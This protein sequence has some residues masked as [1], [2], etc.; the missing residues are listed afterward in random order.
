MGFCVGQ[1]GLLGWKRILGLPLERHV[2]LPTEE[3]AAAE[4]K[5]DIGSDAIGFHGMEVRF[6]PLSLPRLGGWGH[7]VV[8]RWGV[9]SSGLVSSA[10]YTDFG[11]HFLFW[12]TVKESN[13]TRA[14]SNIAIAN[15]AGG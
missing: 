11:L 10:V 3:T 8:H 9:G 7:L 13:S 14:R 6:C 1:N 15:S 12:R 5:R 2:D 4:G